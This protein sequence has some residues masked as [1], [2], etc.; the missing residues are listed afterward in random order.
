MQTMALPVV[1]VTS[2]VPGRM[3]LKLPALDVAGREHLLNESVS[4]ISGVTDIRWTKLTNSLV[5][6]YDYR[7]T[8]SATILDQCQRAIV[9]LAASPAIGSQSVLG[10]AP[11]RSVQHGNPANGTVNRISGMMGKAAPAATAGPSSPRRWLLG[12]FL[13]FIGVVLFVIPGVPGLPILF[14]GLALL[15]LA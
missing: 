3:R 4:S 11:S 7:Q 15:E 1:S 6:Y 5:V 13:V 14:M 12:I 10:F 9:L 2:A 8:S